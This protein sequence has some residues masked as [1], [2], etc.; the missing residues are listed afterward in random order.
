[1]NTTAK[2]FVVA[3]HIES[4]VANVFD[5]M[6]K[7]QVAPGTSGLLPAERVSGAIGIGGEHV[8]ATVYIHLPETLA[9]EITRSLLQCTPGQ[10]AGDNEV[11]DVAGELSNMIG[12]TLKSKLNDADIF[13]AMSTPS[14]IRGAFAVEAPPGVRAETFY[15]ICLGKRFAVEVHMQ[16][17]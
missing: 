10:N 17:N 8:N 15:F 6:L 1:M 14:V 13:C 16:L 9:R 3:D 2:Q 12:G 5:T 7:L 11:N 4:I